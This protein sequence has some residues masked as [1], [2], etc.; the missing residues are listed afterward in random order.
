MFHPGLYCSNWEC[1]RATTVKCPLR[2]EEMLQEVHWHLV[3]FEEV[4][5]TSVR[6]SIGPLGGSMNLSTAFEHL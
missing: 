6:G 2:I 3:A 4:L 5:A 1:P